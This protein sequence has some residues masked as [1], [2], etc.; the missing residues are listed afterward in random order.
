MAAKPKQLSVAK[1]VA[2]NRTGL[3]Y[4]NRLLLPFHAHFISVRVVMQYSSA[5]SGG[6]VIS[7]FSPNSKKASAASAPFGTDLYLLKYNDLREQFGRHKGRLL[8][9]VV[10]I[11]EDVLK[12]S[13]HKTLEC[14]FRDDLPEV[15]FWLVDDAE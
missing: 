2:K 12:L 11:G 5:A 15:K 7:D 14:S 13:K 1:A 10:E 8:I 4:G 9:Q 3:T 6:E